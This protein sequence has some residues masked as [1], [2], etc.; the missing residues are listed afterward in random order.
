MFPCSQIFIDIIAYFLIEIISLILIRAFN[1][2]AL[3]L[4]GGDTDLIADAVML[5]LLRPYKRINGVTVDAE[6]LRCFVDRIED[7]FKV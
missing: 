1:L 4:F 7:F 5:D 2:Q 3:Q 6:D